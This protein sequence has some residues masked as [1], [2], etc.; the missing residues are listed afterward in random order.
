VGPDVWMTLLG[1][2]GEQQ[3]FVVPGSHIR[4]APPRT[5]GTPV[6]DTAPALWLVA[7]GAAS[8]LVAS[9][10]GHVLLGLPSVRVKVRHELHIDAD[11]TPRVESYVSVANL[12]AVDRVPR[13]TQT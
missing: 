5:I 9:I 13:S 6:N 10:I 11:K 4:R 1:S 12:R 8:G 2:W 3:C 7:T